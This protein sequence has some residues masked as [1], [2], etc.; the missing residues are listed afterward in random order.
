MLAA[1]DVPLA[2][3][4][5]ESDQVPGWRGDGD[6]QHQGSDQGQ[7]TPSC[8]F[9]SLQPEQV[10]AEQDHR[11]PGRLTREY[12]SS[13]WRLPDSP[14]DSIIRTLCTEEKI[15]S[16]SLSVVTRGEESSDEFWIFP[17]GFFL[18][19]PLI[20]LDFSPTFDKSIRLKKKLSPST[21]QISPS[22][23][24]HENLMSL[25]LDNVS[26]FSLISKTCH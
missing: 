7:S 12:F 2:D 22:R 10:R 17:A 6:G 18:N 9:L 19:F 15:E 3:V 21:F 23:N 26:K 20:F 24:L 11:Y 14:Y 5:A 8:H 1:G 16:E 13:G 4:P 25:F